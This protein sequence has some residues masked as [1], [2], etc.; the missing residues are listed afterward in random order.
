MTRN[1]TMTELTAGAFRALGPA[2]AI[3]EGLFAPFY[4]RDIKRRISIARVAG[5]TGAVER[6]PAQR[7]LAVYEVEV[8]DGDIRVRA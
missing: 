3:P 6:E 4:L 8:V 2:D 5:D 1:S 7:P